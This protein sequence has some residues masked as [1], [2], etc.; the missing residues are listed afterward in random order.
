MKWLQPSKSAQK[1]NY[2]FSWQITHTP[3]SV[4]EDET[5][6]NQDTGS[7]VVLTPATIQRGSDVTG[8]GCKG[9]QKGNNVKRA[10]EK[11]GILWPGGSGTTLGWWCGLCLVKAPWGNV[12]V[13][14]GRGQG[15]SSD[16]KEENQGLWSGILGSLFR[17][18]FQCIFLTATLQWIC[19]TSLKVSQSQALE[20]C[21]QPLHTTKHTVSAPEE[22]VVFEVRKAH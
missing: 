3:V 9:G 17:C 21:N 2:V 6:A 20:E 8:T 4:T 15:F 12:F 11:G 7:Y 16:L 22:A 5:I 14:A 19:L 18:T 1:L 10:I 13:C